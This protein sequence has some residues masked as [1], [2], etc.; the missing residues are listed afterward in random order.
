MDDVKGVAVLKRGKFW[1]CLL[2]H[3]LVF[4]DSTILIT[5]QMI[6][7]VSIRGFAGMYIPIPTC[8]F[9]VMGNPQES[10]PYISWVF[11]RDKNPQ[12]KCHLYWLV[13]TQRFLVFTPDKCGEMKGSNFDEFAYF[14]KGLVQPPIGWPLGSGMRE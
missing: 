2:V 13:A 12:V 14:S 7:W 4:G 3:W 9:P 6:T 1:E 8:G 10:K 11:M 5:R